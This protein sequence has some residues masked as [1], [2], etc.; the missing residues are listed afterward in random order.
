MGACLISAV[1][2]ASAQTVRGCEALIAIGLVPVCLALKPQ[3]FLRTWM[4]LGGMYGVYV[5]LAVSWLTYTG[6]GYGW[7]LL[8]VS[9]YGVSFLSI[10]AACCWAIRLSEPSARLL[11]LPVAWV[12]MEF[13]QRL[14]LLHLTWVQLADPVAKWPVLSQAAALGGPEILSYPVVAIS[15]AI[16]VACLKGSRGVK[17]V[18]AAQGLGTLLM[19]VIF[20]IVHLNAAP[21]H[22]PTVRISVIQPNVS[23]LEKWDHRKRLGVLAELDGLIDGTIDRNP[24]IYVLPE[25]AVTGFV[26]FEDDLTDWVKRTVVRL[27]RPVLFGTLDRTQDSSQTYNVAIMVTPYDTVTTYRKIHLVPVAEYIPR[28]GPLRRLLVLARGG[29]DEFTA[30]NERTL[31]ELPGNIK[32]ATLI[33]FEDIF[34][35]LV[36]SFVSGGAK[37]LI[38]LTNTEWFKKSSQG[39]EHL[40]RAQLTAISVGVPMIRC[41]N[42]GISA[43]IDRNG[44]ILATV[45]A[46]DGNLLMVAGASV[47]SVPLDQTE[48]VYRRF[49]DSLPLMA[50]CIVIAISIA[51]TRLAHPRMK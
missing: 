47:F 5:A 42:S 13:T 22:G 28:L 41:T 20:G 18:A 37:G 38:V 49:G 6:K 19:T 11:F 14:T 25:T 43:A 30:G 26:R 46:A 33:C 24:D 39:W 27:R 34:P 8:G 3:R 10:P 23:Q 29:P 44:R 48:T 9:L 17:I 40:R 1:L 7:I 2:L 35:D 45:K 36:R 32:F 4:M 51:A 16:A 31:F 50:L 15:T 21:I 12:L